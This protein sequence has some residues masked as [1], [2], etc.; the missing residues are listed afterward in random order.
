MRVWNEGG[1]YSEA[2]SD[3]VKIEPSQP[4]ERGLQVRDKAAENEH[5]RWWPNLRLPPLNQSTVDSDIKYLSSPADV[6]LIISRGLSNETSNKTDYIF[7]HHLFSP[8][9]E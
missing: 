4:P 5:L 8:T 7:D 9:A 2:S 6:E 1:I 3:G